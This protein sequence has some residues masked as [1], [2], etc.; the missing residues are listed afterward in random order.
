M[1]NTI[2]YLIGHYGVGKLTVAKALC[3]ATAAR[4]LDNHLVNNVV[5]TL[6]R[7]DGKTPLPKAIWTHIGHIREIAFE[8]IETL[9]PPE[10]SY[11]LTNALQDHDPIDRQWY[12]RTVE[13]A[14]RRNALFVPVLVDCD[15]AAHALRI[16]TP[17]R[18]ANLKHTDVASGLA[19]RHRVK[20]LTIEHPNLMQ[21]DTTHLQPAEAAQ[22]IIA[23]AERLAR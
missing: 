19:R 7:A 14:R 18:A 23:H 8:V 6:V 17:E 9:A 3:A 16:D 21:L 11:V 4:L 22:Q 2:V 1:K 5:F 20:T 12:E 13:M 10:F 15:E